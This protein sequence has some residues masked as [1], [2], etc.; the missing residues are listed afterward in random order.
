M[1]PLFCMIIMMRSRYLGAWHLHVVK[2]S[3]NS[4]VLPICGGLSKN[5]LF[6]QTHADVLGLPVVL[7]ETTESVLLGAAILGATALGIQGATKILAEASAM[8]C[9]STTSTTTACKP[10][11]SMAIAS[12]TVCTPYSS[13]TEACLTANNPYSILTEASASAS[14]P[15]STIMETM[16]SMGGEGKEVLPRQE[17]AGYHAAKFKV[18]LKLLDCQLECADVMSKWEK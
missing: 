2:S 9:K 6:V 15:P 11:S 17:V 1:I 3:S 4:Q 10:P 5:E 12:V 7:P 8:A 18:F 13:K 14:S 16:Q